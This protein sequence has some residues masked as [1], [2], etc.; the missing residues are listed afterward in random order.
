MS[1]YLTP[2]K[3][4]LLALISLYTESVVPSAATIPVLSFLISQVLPVNSVTSRNDDLLRS[5]DISLT[6]DDFQKATINHI[7]GIP[8]RTVWDLLLNKLWKINSFD[9]LHVFFDTLSLLLQKT[10]EQLQNEAEDGADTDSNPNRMLLSRTSPLGAFVRRAQLEFTRL[11][12]HDGLTLWK[13]FVAYR[14][15][16]LPQWK[17]RNQTAGNTSFDVNLQQDRLD[18]GDRL[19]EVAYGEL[20]TEASQVAGVSTEDVEKLLEYQVDQMQ[21]KQEP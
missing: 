12:F 2:S 15:P 11:Q 16:S 4:G 7:S 8:G 19:T 10:P 5:R 18:L 6:L 9:A 17:K 13:S 14:A 1:R 20:R 3:V 21:S